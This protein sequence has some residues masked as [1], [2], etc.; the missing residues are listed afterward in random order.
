MTVAE[1]LADE[2]SAGEAAGPV[3]AAVVGSVVP[4]RGEGIGVEA[5]APEYQQILS[6]LARRKPPVGCG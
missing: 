3:R 4:H 6:V 2:P 5:L 1:V